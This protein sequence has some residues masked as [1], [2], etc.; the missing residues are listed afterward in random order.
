IK[1]SEK[2]KPEKRTD[3]SAATN[4]CDVTRAHFRE[5]PINGR[6][7]FFVIIESLKARPQARLASGTQ[8][9]R[10]SRQKRERKIGTDDERCALVKSVG[11]LIRE[12][13]F[14]N[15]THN[16]TLRLLTWLSPSSS[17]FPL[18]GDMMNSQN[19][20]SPVAKQ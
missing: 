1:E 19:D 14:S 15:E 10:S 3:S 20:Q 12:I 17:S 6:L 18:A 4:V 11:T 9:G 13:K 16:L 2:G 5:P 8:R 7:N